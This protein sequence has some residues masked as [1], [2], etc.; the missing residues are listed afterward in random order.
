MLNYFLKT[1]QFIFFSVCVLFV[2]R[3]FFIEFAQLDGRSMENT[4]IDEEYFLVDKFSLL[5]R[6]PQRGDVVQFMDRKT[7]RLIIKRIVGLPGERVFIKQNSVFIVSSNGQERKLYEPYLK[8][9]ISTYSINRHPTLYDIIPE[10]YYFVLGDNRPESGD[11]RHFGSIPRFEIN[12]LA[13][14]PLR[15]SK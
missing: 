11:S 1:L 4:Y 6:P 8:P 9:Y 12:G 10:N 15:F 3:T 13:T 14:P 2:A 7:N 5:F